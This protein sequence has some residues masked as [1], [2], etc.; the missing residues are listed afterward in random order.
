MRT[1]TLTV[2]GI[3]AMAL[4]L[5]ALLARA[6]DPGGPR[7]KGP[8]AGGPASRPGDRPDGGFCLIPPFAVE[9]MKLTDEQRKKLDDLTKDTKAKLDA[10]LTADQQEILRE[11]RPPRP[12]PGSGGPGGPGD[13]PGDNPDGG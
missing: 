2:V 4:S 7:G 11:A 12:D 8:R 1:L 10:I 5:T 6:G 3:A 13:G 9:K